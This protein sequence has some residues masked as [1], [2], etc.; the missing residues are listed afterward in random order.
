MNVKLIK[1]M[2]RCC[3]AADG[4]RLGQPTL[5]HGELCATDKIVAVRYRE[6]DWDRDQMPRV[7]WQL[8]AHEIEVEGIKP[9][10]KIGV[11]PEGFVI[12]KGKSH[13]YPDH[14]Y[15]D[16]ANLWETLLR[17]PNDWQ[18]DYDPE[19]VRR[20][21]AVFE[22]AGANVSFRD[23]GS[24]LHMSGWNNKTLASVEALVC[25]CRR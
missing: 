21:L 15:P 3:A 23:T 12:P 1:A 19:Q 10:T 25:G 2:Q 24:V 16:L 8:W 20:V 22:A 7:P 13:G 9:S 5:V 14:E 6:S 4:G 18:L 17:N 11:S